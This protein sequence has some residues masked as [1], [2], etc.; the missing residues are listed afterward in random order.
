MEKLST[1]SLKNYEE[2]AIELGNDKKKLS[3]IKKEIENNC[4][5][6]PLF[7]VQDFTKDL[8]KIFLKLI[9]KT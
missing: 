1:N 7:R 6:S 8:E 3:Q 5:N 2:M 9:Q 4:L